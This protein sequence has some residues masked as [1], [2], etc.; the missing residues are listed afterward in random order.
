M[1]RNPAPQPD[2]D[3]RDLVFMAGGLVGPRHPDA[4]ASLGAVAAD[5]EGGQRADDPFLEASY[6]GADVGPPPLQVEH[7]IGDP[8][9]RAVIGELAAAS[10]LKHRK[11]RVEQVARFA[12]GAG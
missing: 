5:V 4:G 12:A 9:A 10:S 2:A 1:E 7:R 11:A 6:I 8:L 3:R